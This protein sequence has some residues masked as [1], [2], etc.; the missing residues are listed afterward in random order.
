MKLPDWINEKLIKVIKSR[1]KN[2]EYKQKSFQIEDIISN[3]GKK[4]IFWIYFAE[5][6]FE[7]IIYINI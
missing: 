7:K 2:T 5:D 4:N 6:N 3:Y 1:K